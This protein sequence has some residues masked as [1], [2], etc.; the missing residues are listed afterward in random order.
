L[1]NGVSVPANH[2]PVTGRTPFYEGKEEEVTMLRMLDSMTH[3]RA[4]G[5]RV[6]RQLGLRPEEQEG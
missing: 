1:A 3:E 4:T 6:E 5:G 2:R